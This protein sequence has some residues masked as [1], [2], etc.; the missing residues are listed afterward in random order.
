MASKPKMIRTMN[1]CGAEV[2]WLSLSL[3]V[4]DQSSLINKLLGMYDCICIYIIERKARGII[5]VIM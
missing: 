5:Q 1:F 4:S 3:S 2:L